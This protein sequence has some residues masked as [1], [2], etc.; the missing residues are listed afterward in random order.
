MSRRKKNYGNWEDDYD[1]GATRKVGDNLLKSLQAPDPNMS[2]LLTPSGDGFA[3]AGFRVT[4][5]GFESLEGIDAETWQKVGDALLYLEGS[6]QWLIGDWLAFGENIGYGDAT[7]IA[8]QV[9]REAKTLHNWA[10]VAR[11][12]EFSLRRENLSFTHHKIIVEECAR[13]EH[14]REARHS[15]LAYAAEHGLSVRELKQ[16]I[17]AHGTPDAIGQTEAA[18]PALAD[19]V[20][21]TP[22]V[23]NP[24]AP[25]LSFH[26]VV[27]A[28]NAKPTRQRRGYR[29]EVTR[30]ARD[31]IEYAAHAA[32]DDEELAELE[33]MTKAALKAVWARRKTR[34]D[35]NQQPPLP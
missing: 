7:R 34:N 8:E 17:R 32:E 27:S 12:I 15:W 6:I 14:P 18:A 2:G 25:L 16:A 24:P 21:A 1:E 3:L 29:H 13:Q 19:D 20:S 10:W 9:G 11:T 22:E 5:V 23:D 31:V 28:H 4:S 26:D 33:E 35:D 30:F